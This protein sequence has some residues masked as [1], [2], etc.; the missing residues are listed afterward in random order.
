MSCLT[1][2]EVQNEKRKRNTKMA[3]WGTLQSRN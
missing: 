2:I 1:I 3:Q